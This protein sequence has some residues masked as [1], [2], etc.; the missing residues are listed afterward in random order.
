M[1]AEESTI[2]LIAE[3][4]EDQTVLLAPTVGRFTCAQPAGRVLSAGA[5]AGAL[6]VLG[7]S[8]TLVVPAGVLGRVVSRRPERVHEP[9]GFGTVL[10]EL[11]P[12]EAGD[13]AADAPDTTAGASTRPSFRAP[14]SGRFWHRPAPADPPFVKKGDVI[15]FENVRLELDA[16]GIKAVDADGSDLGSH[17]AF[18][19]AW[20]QFHPE[21]A[22][23]P[24]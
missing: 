13:A 10:Y 1:S 24:G 21:T 14:H 3:Q 20:S 7:R 5:P 11:A 2:E 9:V 12:I 23:W 4:R 6:Q 19:F 16:G 22:L 15:A 8:H 18:W 17:Q